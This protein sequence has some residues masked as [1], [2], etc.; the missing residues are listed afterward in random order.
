MSEPPKSP[1]SHTS[2]ASAWA[3]TEAGRRAFRYQFRFDQKEAFELDEAGEPLDY[4]VENHLPSRDW[5]TAKKNSLA[6][7]L[8]NF[9]KEKTF[10]SGSLSTTIPILFSIRAEYFGQLVLDLAALANPLN[11]GINSNAKQDAYDQADRIRQAGYDAA[12]TDNWEALERF[13]VDVRLLRDMSP[14]AGED[15]W[16]AILN[17][18]VSMAIDKWSSFLHTTKGRPPPQA[19]PRAFSRNAPKDVR[20][21]P[22]GFPRT[23]KPNNGVYIHRTVNGFGHL[24]RRQKRCLTTRKTVQI[25]DPSAIL[26]VITTEWRASRDD[27]DSEQAHGQT[28]YSAVQG[29]GIFQNCQLSVKVLMLCV[30]FG[31]AQPWAS[32]WPGKDS[33]FDVQLVRGEEIDLGTLKGAISCM[34]MPYDNAQ[35]HVLSAFEIT[36]EQSNTTSLWKDLFKEIPLTPGPI[37]DWRHI[38]KGK[39]TRKAKVVA[40]AKVG[41]GGEIMEVDVEAGMVAIEV[42][43]PQVDGGRRVRM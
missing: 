3:G 19:M 30:G 1:L 2:D 37:V 34:L 28:M 13:C 9:N 14:P 32:S 29:A 8:A 39:G 35:N 20:H 22:I 6:G 24:T 33:S 43:G 36:R 17:R 15:A 23:F 18:F 10:P 26:P 40:E 25:A 4:I 41:A 11:P 7:S 12:I 5:M 42:E 27:S 38:P 21:D 31:W 16:A